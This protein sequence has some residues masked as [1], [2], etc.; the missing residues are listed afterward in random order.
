MPIWNSTKPEAPDHEALVRDFY[1]SKELDA[2]TDDVEF[3]CLGPTELAT[4]GHYKGKGS[5]QTF[6]N[7][8]LPSTI[9][10]KGFEPSHMC[11][12]GSLVVVHGSE[13]CTILQDDATDAGRPVTNYFIHTF[14]FRDGKIF[15]LRLDM[16]LIPDDAGI[17]NPL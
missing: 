17:P 16:N 15:K 8:I 1:S 6:F 7:K 10:T 4:F 14:Y 13:T 11:A 9:E 12:S 2:V 3:F 5:I